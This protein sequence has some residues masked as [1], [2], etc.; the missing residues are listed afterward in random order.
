ML[1]PRTDRNVAGGEAWLEHVRA[2]A[3]D[4]AQR[5]AYLR[6]SAMLDMAAA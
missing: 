2:M 1:L 4:P 3:A 6:T 5:Q